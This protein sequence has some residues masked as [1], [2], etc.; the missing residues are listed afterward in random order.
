MVTGS[1]VRA[2]SSQENFFSHNSQSLSA[3]LQLPSTP[4]VVGLNCRQRKNL[5]KE[6]SSNT[7]T[8]SGNR[9]VSNHFYNVQNIT[10]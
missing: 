2:N 7:N 9:S 5:R 10:N 1:G 4:K 3:Q 6:Q 8:Y